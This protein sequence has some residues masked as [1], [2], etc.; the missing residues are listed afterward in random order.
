MKYILLMIT[1]MMPSVPAYAH[2]WEGKKTWAV[3]LLQDLNEVS[4]CYEYILK[5]NFQPYKQT[6]FPKMLA[7]DH[8]QM[9]ADLDK[10]RAVHPD[11][12][13]EQFLYDH[14][15]TKDAEKLVVHMSNSKYINQTMV[16]I[17]IADGMIRPAQ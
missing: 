1:L 7:E 16:Y 12:E 2:E 15:E 11:M 6:C 4:R 9:L 8:N 14:F 5:S 3:Q 13:I 10:E 17:F